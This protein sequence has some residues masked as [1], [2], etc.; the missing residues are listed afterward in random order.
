[1]E[2]FKDV[3]EDHF[4]VPKKLETLQAKITSNSPPPEEKKKK[5]FYSELVNKIK[6]NKNNWFKDLFKV[7]N[8]IETI[9][10]DKYVQK[11]SV[12]SSVQVLRS[13]G[14]CSLGLRTTECS[15]TLTYPLRHSVRSI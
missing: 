14:E 3:D 7:N 6:K 4:L 13:V 2:N 1:M 8:E 15:I 10:N 11:G 9:I 5:S 12:P